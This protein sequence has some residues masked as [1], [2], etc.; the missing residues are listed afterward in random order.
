MSA[1]TD[2]AKSG[3]HPPDKELLRSGCLRNKLSV[4]DVLW[5]PSLQSI[6]NSL[7]VCPLILHSGFDIPAVCVANVSGSDGTDQWCAGHNCTS[8]WQIQA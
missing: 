5:I 7:A 6:S 3:I 1:K 2:F 8:R 4:T